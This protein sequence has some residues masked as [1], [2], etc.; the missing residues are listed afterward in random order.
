M[1]SSLVH[2]YQ[3]AFSGE[4]FPLITGAPIL[5]FAENREAGYVEVTKEFWERQPHTALKL[6]KKGKETFKK[7]PKKRETVNR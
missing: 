7:I 2:Q 3:L 1:I 5:A 4:I 6:K